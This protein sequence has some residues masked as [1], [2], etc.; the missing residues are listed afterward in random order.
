MQKLSI[1]VVFC[2][3]DAQYIPS[4]ISNIS[5]CISFN[6]E[7]IF[8]DNRNDK[9]STIDT[10]HWSIYPME[11]NYYQ[12]A[13]RK[14]GLKHV[15][16]DYVWF[17]DADDS[18]RSV[19][20]DLQSSPDIL[21]FRYYR[22]FE[23]E[24]GLK[25]TKDQLP[26]FQS[27][28]INKP[29]IFTYNTYKI[30]HCALWNKWFK[31]DF[32]KSIYDKYIP[33]KIECVDHEDCIIVLLALKYAQSI[34]CSN[35]ILYEMNV[36]RSNSSNDYISDIN[37]YKH[38]MIGFRFLMNLIYKEFSSEEQKSLKMDNQF[39]GDIYYRFTICDSFIQ[40][41]VFKNIIYPTLS[42]DEIQRAAL[43]GN[44]KDTNRKY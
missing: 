42:V 4:L 16:G 15:T 10:A 2:D 36:S 35:Q 28:S 39:L 29:D 3:K 43:V 26:I 24:N 11:K 38:L 12:M 41:D 22:F 20:I 17:I 30:I 9:T 23:I 21:A 5:K 37:Q 1:I 31:T 7:I 6:Y 19:K 33:E 14:E 8:I 40:E 25:K 13:A 18:I 32:I 44:K 27:S 34:K